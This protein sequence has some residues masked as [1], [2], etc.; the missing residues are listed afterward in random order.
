[1]TVKSLRIPCRSQISSNRADSVSYSLVRVSSFGF[2]TLVNLVS[3]PDSAFIQQPEEER[4]LLSARGF[5]EAKSATIN[6]AM[7]MRYRRMI[8]QKYNFN[9]N[10][11]VDPM[12]I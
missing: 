10:N 12:I 6:R 2:C 1:M 11:L 4:K 8:Q 7:V 3:S 9:S 5:D